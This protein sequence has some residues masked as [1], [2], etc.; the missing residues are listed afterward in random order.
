MM[1]LPLMVFDHGAPA[2][3]VK[4]YENSILLGKCEEAVLKQVT[5]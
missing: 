2:E 1:E 3:R 4:K 5:T